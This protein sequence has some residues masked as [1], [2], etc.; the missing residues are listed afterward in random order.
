MKS[1]LRN[2]DRASRDMVDM[3]KWFALICTVALVVICVGA[4]LTLVY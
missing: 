2:L 3:F 4:Y 1:F